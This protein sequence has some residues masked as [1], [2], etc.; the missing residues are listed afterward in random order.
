MKLISASASPFARKV[1]V[2]LHETG[3]T[4]AVEI[5]DVMTTAIDTNPDLAAANPAG[6][7]PALVREEGPAVY[8]SRVICR[9]LDDRFKAGLYPESRLFET[10]TLEATADAMM[11]AALLTVYEHRVRPPEKVFD[12]WIEAQWTK[13]ARCVG[14]VN[15]RWM[16]HLNGPLDMSHVAIGCALGYLDFRQPDRNWREGAGALDDW[17]AVFSTRESMKATAPE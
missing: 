14:A 3:Q 10:L 11:D 15:D 4:D 1:R 9:Y 12:G 2:L 8:D 16:S 13:V 7:L 17:Y 5:V 6:K